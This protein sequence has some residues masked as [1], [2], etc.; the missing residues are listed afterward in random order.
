MQQKMN[1]NV[2]PCVGCVNKQ[3]I[4]TVCHAPFA[5]YPDMRGTL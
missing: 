5:S 3:R 1:A 4:L 2:A